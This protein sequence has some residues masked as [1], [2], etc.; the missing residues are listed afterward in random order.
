[1]RAK[2]IID[3]VHK[4][5]GTIPSDLT[6][7]RDSGRHK[8]VRV[9]KSLDEGL[10]AFEV[11]ISGKTLENRRHDVGKSDDEF[12][13]HV[14]RNEVPLHWA[15]QAIRRLDHGARVEQFCPNGAGRDI[16]TRGSNK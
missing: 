4:L 8:T 14:G 6:K 3:D 7:M 15:Q 1:M 16:A 2:P 13:T 12:L 5:R 10:R 9:R 11:R